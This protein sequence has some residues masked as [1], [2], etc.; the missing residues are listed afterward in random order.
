M[1]DDKQTRTNIVYSIVQYKII[2]TSYKHI[3]IILLSLCVITILTYDIYIND[4]GFG[5]HVIT[6]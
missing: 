3:L 2:H 6:M 4:K 5:F 1:F